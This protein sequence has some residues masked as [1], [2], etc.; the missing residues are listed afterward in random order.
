MLA[1]IY[2][3][4]ALLLIMFQAAPVAEFEASTPE[5]APVSEARQEFPQLNQPEPTN[6]VLLAPVAW[7]EQAPK[8]GALIK[9]R[10]R[11]HAL[12][13][14]LSAGEDWGVTLKGQ[15]Q[16]AQLIWPPPSPVQPETAL[17][18][19]S[20]VVAGKL[21]ATIDLGA[22]PPQFDEL[23][24]EFTNQELL[25]KVAIATSLD[26]ETYSAFSVPQLVYQRI[27]GTDFVR[28]NNIN[29][30]PQDCR[31][32]KLQITSETPPQLVTVAARKTQ[33]DAGDEYEVPARF[34]APLF[35]PDT[36]EQ[37]LPIELESNLLPVV[38]IRVAAAEPHDPLNLRV[39]RLAPAGGIKR[40]VAA[41]A[42]GGKLE[43]FDL[44]RDASNIN[45]FSPEMGDEPWALALAA[46]GAE[47]STF[48]EVRVWVAEV[49]IATLMPE[50][51]TQL[52]LRLHEPGTPRPAL[53][54]VSAAAL[55]DIPCAGEFNAVQL[56]PP[57][58][59]LNGPSAEVVAELTGEVRRYKYAVGYAAF[60]VFCVLIG[61]FALRRRAPE[62]RGE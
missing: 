30:N 38:R 47:P 3:V 9:L 45:C 49:Y 41:T 33:A 32:L 2:P 53:T 35:D 43:A 21:E 29:C 36:H 44:A 28:I 58:L 61:C 19:T 42:W 7:Q 24:L 40:T 20:A 22:A 11:D 57:P 37:L 13:S 54:S 12:L 55:D 5:A 51:G 26:G 60:G 62:A 31:Y 50:V 25:A 52:A 27:T 56:P 18:F 23:L 59:G 14:L 48:S 6:Q 39:V 15:A 16:P 10:V 1:R 17:S 4:I 8:P 46:G 34:G